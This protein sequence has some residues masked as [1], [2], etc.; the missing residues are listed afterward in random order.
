MWISGPIASG[1]RGAAM[2]ASGGQ[3]ETITSKASSA[4][5]A[6]FRYREVG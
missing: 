3:N 5:E 4:V 2:A 6:C 1:S